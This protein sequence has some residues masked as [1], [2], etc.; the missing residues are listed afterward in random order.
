MIY[1]TQTVTPLNVPMMLLEVKGLMEAQRADRLIHR[2]DYS[3]IL[4]TAVY[5]RSS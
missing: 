2:P 4:D 3:H 5:S 1:L